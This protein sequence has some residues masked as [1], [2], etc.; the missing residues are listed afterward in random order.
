M[1]LV[2]TAA[3]ALATTLVAAPLVR[4]GLIRYSFMDNPNAR[5]S[6]QAP[7]PR[8]GG[9]ACLAGIAAGTTASAL[10]G[11][12]DAVPIALAATALAFVGLIDDRLRL[13][14]I[15]RLFAQVL[16]GAV[17]GA[18]AGG[19]EWAVRGAILYPV[20]VNVVN[21]MDGING[22]TA[23]SLGIWGITISG[24]GLAYGA[25]HLATLGAATAAT[26]LGFL[27]WN[28]P[29]ARMFLGDVG[30]YLFGALAAGGILFGTASGAPL[31]LMSAPFIIYFADVT[32]TLLRR[33]LRKKPL[34]EAHREHI[35]QQLA[36]RAPT[37]MH[38]TITVAI[39]STLVVTIW[40]LLDPLLATLGTVT[41]VGLYLISPYILDYHAA[42][43]NASRTH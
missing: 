9:L 34:T 42:R 22:L 37:H 13:P 6:H 10:T 21:F 40:V 5:S 39:A 12:T 16:V 43:S 28:A 2:I 7:V 30:S 15:P 36:Q 31:P 32:F 1:K 29:R 18:A 33:A 3:A 27:P 19:L 17:V 26:A 8:G 24:L 35:Y 14:A 23:A 11:R 38:V 20:V 25:S 4:K 41:L